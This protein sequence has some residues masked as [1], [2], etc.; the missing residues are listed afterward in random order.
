MPRVPAKQVDWPH[1]RFDDAHTGVNPFEKTISRKNVASL[2]LAWQA[3]LGR[4]VYSSSPAVVDGVVYIGSIDGTLWAYPADGCG[5]SLCTTPLWR[6]TSLAQI[7]DSPTVADGI[8]YVGSQTS[9]DSNDGKLNAFD[10]NGCGKPVCKPL[11]KGLAGKDSILDSSPTV[12]DGTVFVGAY[13]G[14]LY[15]FPASGCGQKT[16]KP[17]WTGATGG[18]DRVDADRR[19]RPG[20][21]RLGRREPLRVRRRRLW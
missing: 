19:R 8:V 14:R 18:H 20:P 10:A 16:C 6:S 12:A 3:Q 15:A 7:V 1:F 13:D 21:G 2:G 9:F 5:Q 4:L 17:S 11:W